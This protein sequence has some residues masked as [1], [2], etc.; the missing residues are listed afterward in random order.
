MFNGWARQIIVRV[1]TRPEGFPLGL[2]I[3]L[4]DTKMFVTFREDGNYPHR[5]NCCVRKVDLMVQEDVG[6]YWVLG[7]QDGVLDLI[8]RQARVGEQAL[9]LT[10]P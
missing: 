6:G 2:W 5:H 1:D 7:I 10:L 3:L 4:H 9:A 8:K